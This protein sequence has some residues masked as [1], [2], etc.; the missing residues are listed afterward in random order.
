[1]SFVQ[2]E[3]PSVDLDDAPPR[4]KLS[5]LQKFQ[6]ALRGWKF[7]IRGHASFF[8]HFFVTALVVATAIVLD[9]EVI[10]WCM[11][12]GCIGLV[13]TAELFNSAIE[14]LFRGLPEDIKSRVWP[15]LDI[16]AG[17]VLLASLTASIVGLIIFLPRLP[18]LASLLHIF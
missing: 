18:K 3:S 14:T 4:K 7:G 16:S 17:A 8:V 15:S 10:E 2:T 6:V 1:M 13:L 12:L 11:L 9:C 5:W